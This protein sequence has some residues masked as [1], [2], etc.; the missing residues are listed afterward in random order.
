VFVCRLDFA[1]CSAALSALGDIEESEPI[2]ISLAPI[3]SMFIEGLIIS[4][5]P[6]GDPTAACA[7]VLGLP[8]WQSECDWRSQQDRSHAEAQAEVGT[9][10]TD[11]RAANKLLPRS[12]CSNITSVRKTSTR[13]R[14]F[15]KNAI[16]SL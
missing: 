15:R 3:P 10:S 9:M 13:L 5:S 4:M 16:E 6:E 12:I 11:K 14:Q 7:P 8:G 1:V 2:F